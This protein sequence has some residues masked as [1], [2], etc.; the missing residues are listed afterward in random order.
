ML[1]TITPFSL[2]MTCTSSWVVSPLQP[3]NIYGLYSSNAMYLAKY[4]SIAPTKENFDE[5]K[6][7]YRGQRDSFRSDPRSLQELT[8]W[9]QADHDFDYQ[10]LG[11]RYYVAERLSSVYGKPFSKAFQ[12]LHSEY[13]LHNPSS[14]ILSST[15]H[16][17]IIGN[18][19]SY[20][21]RQYP[22]APTEKRPEGQGFAHTLVI[23]RARVYNVVDP[24]ATKNACFLLKE[25]HAHFLN[26]WSLPHNAGKTALLARARKALLDQ[27]AKL[28]SSAPHAAYTDPI[29]TAIFAAFEQKSVEYLHLDAD[30]D[31]VFGFHVFPENSIGHLHMHVFPSKEGLREWSTRDYDYKTVPLEAVLEVEE[32]DAAGE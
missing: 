2:I 6:A 12:R 14:L 17:Y 21:S 32:E 5:L 4:G 30:R 15:P 8:A 27:D 3:P 20:D 23:P 10:L 31:F 9:K 28:L 16:S 13:A 22:L 1:T 18:M 7:H 29:R 19:A 11:I 26:F 25:M 24:D